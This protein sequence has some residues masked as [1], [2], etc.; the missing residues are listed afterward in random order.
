MVL[1]RT[2]GDFFDKEDTIAK[3]RRLVWR[4]REWLCR[5]LLLA[6][7]GLRRGQA[8]LAVYMIKYVASTDNMDS[9]IIVYEP[10]KI[11]REYW[12]NRSR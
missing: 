9:R 8:H 1:Q 5:W 7:R 11:Q 3:I 10:S 6:C 2:A 12:N 4:C